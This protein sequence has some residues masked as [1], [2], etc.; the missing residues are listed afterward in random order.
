MDSILKNFTI[1]Y[2]EDEQTVASIVTEVLTDIFKTV[3]VGSN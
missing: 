3:Y 1:L 2:M